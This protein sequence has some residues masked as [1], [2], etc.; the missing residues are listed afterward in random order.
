MSRRQRFR[1]AKS[2]RARSNPRP[3]VPKSCILTTRTPVQMFHYAFLQVQRVPWVLRLPVVEASLS[4]SS[5]VGRAR[6]SSLRIRLCPSGEIAV[7]SAALCH[8]ARRVALTFVELHGVPRRCS[9]FVC[10]RLLGVNIDCRA[11]S[12]AQ[13]RAQVHTGSLGRRWWCA[14]RRAC[15]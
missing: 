14:F 11:C 2:D 9:V 7:S 1:E 8:C 4:A 12:D 3:P 13:R 10:Q 15:W 5:R 6:A